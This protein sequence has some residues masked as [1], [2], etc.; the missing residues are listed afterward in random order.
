[1]LWQE[2]LIS[3]RSTG[4]F[5]MIRP[6]LLLLLYTGKNLWIVDEFRY[7]YS[8]KHFSQH[9]L[10]FDIVCFQHYVNHAGDQS[11][12]PSVRA[13]LRFLGQGHLS[14][15]SIKSSSS[16]PPPPQK[17]KKKKKNCN[18]FRMVSDTA[19]I[20]HMCIPCGKT[21]SVVPRS[22]SSIKVKIKYQGHN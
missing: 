17:K 18:I 14:R 21:F 16:P 7:C 1:M 2:E 12:H 20:F 11:F 6:Q 22:R 4:S 15:S 10:Q 3:Q 13:F 9:L 19:F 8:V 5:S